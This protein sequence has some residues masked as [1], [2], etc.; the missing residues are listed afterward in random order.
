MPNVKYLGDLGLHE[1]Q[2]PEV[3]VAGV[4]LPRGVAV[5]MHEQPARKLRTN[6]YFEVTDD[7]APEAPAGDAENL[8][9]PAG[10][11]RKG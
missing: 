11:R 2:D 8:D 6:P 1:F 5:P 7:E 4:H 10:K 9:D 3:V